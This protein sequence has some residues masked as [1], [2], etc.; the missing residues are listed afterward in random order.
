MTDAS[1]EPDPQADVFEIQ[2][3]DTLE[4]LVHPLRLRIVNSLTR[5]ELTVREMAGELELPVTRLYYHLNL[6]VEA[7]LIEVV[8]TEKVGASLQRRFRS[9][10]KEY[11]TADSLARL[12]ETDR[13]TAD[14]VTG[15]VLEGARLDAQ[16]LFA[17]LR[18]DADHPNA[19]GVVGRVSLNIAPSRVEYWMSRLAEVVDE[20]GEEADQLDDAQMY[21]FSFVFA[22]LAC[23]LRGGL[24]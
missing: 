5:A 10:A 15:L 3:I 6:L 16:G 13:R 23:P 19:R 9:V 18:V 11:L 8:A 20:I 7:Q 17:Q 22:P 12:I 2:D 24:Q 4:V 21:G 14:L 1:R